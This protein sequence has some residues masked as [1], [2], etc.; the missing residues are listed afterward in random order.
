VKAFYY[1]KKKAQKT[2]A[3]RSSQSTGGTG[4][5]GSQRSYATLETH[6]VLMLLNRLAPAMSLGVVGSMTQHSTLIGSATA[7][8]SSTRGPPFALL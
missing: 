8:Q 1:S 3:R 7:S 2:Q 6:E 5:I 4:Y